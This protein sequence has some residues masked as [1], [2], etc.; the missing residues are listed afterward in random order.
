MGRGADSITSRLVDDINQNRFAEAAVNEKGEYAVSAVDARIA[1]SNNLVRGLSE[2]TLATLLRDVMAKAMA[3]KEKGQVPMS[4]QMMVD[5]LVVVMMA[6]DIDEG[7][8]ERKIAYD[9]LFELYMEYFPETIKAIMPL[10]PEKYGSW[11]DVN[12]ILSMLFDKIKSSSN[13]AFREN[14]KLTAYKDLMKHLVKMYADQLLDDLTSDSPSLAGK[15]AP[16]E[17]R[18]G[19]TKHLAR[20][21]AIQ[22]Y[23]GESF[24]REDGSVIMSF[25]ENSKALKTDPTNQVLKKNLESSKVACYAAYRKATSKLNSSTEVLMCDSSGRWS[26]INPKTV[27]AKCLKKHR[28]GF[29]NE[30][31]KKGD[32]NPRSMNADRIQCAKQFTEFI[33]KCLKD[34]SKARVHGKKLMP[35]EIVSHYLRGGAYDEVLE[36]QWIDMVESLREAGTFNDLLPLVDVSGSMSGLPMEVAIAIGLL[37]AALSPLSEGYFITFES[38][39]R[40]HKVTGKTLQDKVL[41]ARNAP[42]GGSTNFESA[43]NL[44]LSTCQKNN[45]SPEEVAK[46]RLIVLSDMEFD[47]ANGS[48]YYG[49][50]YGYG[51]S[52]G[53]TTPSHNTWTSAYEKIKTGFEKAG[54]A[55]KYAQAYPVP[56]IWF[57]N[58]RASS[59]TFPVKDNVP[60]AFLISGW[61]QNALKSM[62]KGD[63][64]SC[65]DEAPPTA[66]DLLRKEID[67]DRY[68]PVR[69]VVEMV[70]ESH[71]AGYKMPVSP[72]DDDKPSDSSEINSS[73]VSPTTEV[74]EEVKDSSK[75]V[76]P[77][78]SPVVDGDDKQG[79]VDIGDSAD[80][81][82]QLEKLKAEM[83]SMKLAHKIKIETL[84]FEKA[85]ADLEVKKA[86]LDK[87]K[88]DSVGSSYE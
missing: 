4:Q 34:P 26:E 55:S 51:Y 48:S 75:T 7:K 18:N 83:E 64:R 2:S 31:R 63:L 46:L 37:I 78:P 72:D 77:P 24:T 17:A 52:Y 81:A 30:S 9:A 50:S 10:L 8:G 36:A 68:D 19:N 21:I 42:W 22:M 66:Y 35:H 61:S 41:C 76:P 69:K 54:R 80:L 11:K 62:M 38:K 23:R 88:L 56:E 60:G 12:N 58:L 44:V 45:L 87:L 27:P 47:M 15:W 86:N 33:N 6:R 1:F 84:E 14:P 49:G 85:Q 28:K 59:L 3:L 82:S 73:S 67:S 13:G 74:K 71:F 25:D 53:R 65:K 39:C 79:W 43:M 32:H 57:W 20:Y 29:Y 70:Q 16:R 40:W 5:C